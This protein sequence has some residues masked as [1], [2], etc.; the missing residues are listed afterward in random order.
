MVIRHVL[1]YGCAVWHQCLTVAQ[2]QKLESLQKRALRIIHQ[3]IYDMPYESACAYAG[4]QS[5]SVRRHELGKRF[6]PRL[7]NPAAVYMTFFPNDETQILFL[8]F[9]DALPILY[10]GLELTHTDLLFTLP[11]LNINNINKH[12][13]LCALYWYTVYLDLHVM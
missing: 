9:D 7:R 12:I 11:W 8:D 1:E 4:V 3:I 6:F 10:H 5:L 2:S 13:T